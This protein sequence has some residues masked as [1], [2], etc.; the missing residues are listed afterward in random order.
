[1]IK[2]C[3]QCATPVEQR[4]FEGKLRPICPAC[5]Y[6]AFADPKVAATVLIACD[7]EVLLVRRAVDPARGLWCFPGGYVDFGEDP[8]EAARR[9][10][11]EE[12]GIEVHAL[13][14]LDVAF[15]GR[16]IVITYLAEL[17]AL[18]TPTPADDAD[19]AG[20]F[21]PDALPPL[22]FDTVQ[23]ALERWQVRGGAGQ[24]TH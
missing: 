24:G 23:Q 5:G 12:S 21:K 18:V 11:R 15:N 7:N 10:C 9:E 13:T 2:F 17:Q 8:L 4:P 3:P 14:L 16:V 19:L 1:M 20:W 6:I 22:A